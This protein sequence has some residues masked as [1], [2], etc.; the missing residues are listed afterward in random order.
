MLDFFR[1]IG[2]VGRFEGD[3]GEGTD[4]TTPTGSLSLSEA[5][6]GIDSK[7]N[8]GLWLEQYL[9]RDVGAYEIVSSSVPI[10]AQ[11]AA[12]WTE[13]GCG[14]FEDRVCAEHISLR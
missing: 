14:Y 13:N 3:K 9:R 8:S 1:C 11:T 12:A 7:R 4:S 5:S 2:C 10:R 6:G